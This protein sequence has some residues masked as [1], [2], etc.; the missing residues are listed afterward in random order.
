MLFGNLKFEVSMLIRW[1]FAFLVSSAVLLALGGCKK[2]EESGS[3]STTTQPEVKQL[4]AP[5]VKLTPV[6]EGKQ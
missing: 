6:P 2:T 1:C 4:N 5:G 3:K